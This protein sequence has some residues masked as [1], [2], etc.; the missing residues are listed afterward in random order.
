VWKENLVN[1]LKEKGI[2]DAAVIGEVL[3]VPNGKIVVS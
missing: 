2:D 3:P 1:E